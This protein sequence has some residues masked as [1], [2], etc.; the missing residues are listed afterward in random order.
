MY[1]DLSRYFVLF[2]GRRLDHCFL[3]DERG[4]SKTESYARSTITNG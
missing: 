3:A 2:N 1:A 4:K